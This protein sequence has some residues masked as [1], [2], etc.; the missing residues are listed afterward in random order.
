MEYTIHPVHTI[1]T[2]VGDP[3]DFRNYRK[4]CH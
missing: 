3:K 2:E 4:W 1:S